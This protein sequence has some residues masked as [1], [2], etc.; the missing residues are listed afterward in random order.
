MEREPTRF[1]TT[2]MFVEQEERPSMSGRHILAAFAIAVMV[3]SLFADETIPSVLAHRDDFSFWIAA[4]RAVGANGK[5][6]RDALGRFAESAGRTAG[7]KVPE[8]TKRN[9]P[10][11]PRR[12][13]PELEGCEI[14]RAGVIDHFQPTSTIADLTTHAEFIVSGRIAAIR[15]GF[16]GGS[17]GSLLLLSMTETLKGEAVGESYLFYPLARIETSDGLICAK[18][19]GEFVPP[20]VGDR[21]LLFSMV[22]PHRFEGRTIFTVN[23][24]RELV[25]EPQKEP[26]QVPAALKSLTGSALQFEDVVQA[27]RAQ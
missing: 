19:L 6:D 22:R 16:L 20:A 18:P 12:Q 23:T 9:P 24:A 15:Q 17:P 3:P 25:H 1:T 2:D 7:M 11:S 8:W 10:K 26:L 4:E 5:L 27:V 21:V 14:F 13:W